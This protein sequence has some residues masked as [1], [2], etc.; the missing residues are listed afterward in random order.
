MVD[1][2]GKKFGRLTVAEK[3]DLRTK[4]GSIIWLCKCEC[5]KSVNVASG[6]LIRG[7]TKSCGCYN[8]QRIKETQTKQNN[9]DLSGEYGIGYTSNNEEFLF[10]LEDYEK[11]KDNCWCV[12]GNGYIVAPIRGDRTKQVSLSRTIMGVTDNEKDVDH[13]NH[14]LRDNRKLNLRIVTR[15]Q[16][17]MNRTLQS[18][19]TSGVAGVTF[20]KDRNKWCARITI[21]KQT[22][23]LGLFVNFQDAVEARRKAEIEYF[24]EYRYKKSENNN[25]GLINE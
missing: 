4:H 11:I 25:G 9:F 14:N 20:H 5:G 8:K 24:G 17:N 22:I 21:N 13:I 2:T 7:I 16:N 10:D 1:L 6:N 3:T 23:N 15:T 18:N 19:N 12:S